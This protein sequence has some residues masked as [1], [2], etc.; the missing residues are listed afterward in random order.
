MKKYFFE[1]EMIVAVNAIYAI[2]LRSLKRIQ[3]FNRVWNR[4]LA[5]PVRCSTNWAMK[6]LTL[7][8]GQLWVHIW[9]LSFI[10]NTHFFHGNIWTHNWPAPNVSGFL[11][12]LVE[13]RTGIARTRVQTPLK[14]WFFCFFFRLLY[15]I[16]WIAFTATIISF[17]IHFRSSYII[18]FIH[19]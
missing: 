3:D 6:P 16:A 12:Q 1:K 10:I 17:S 2:A 8:V 14:S 7:G 9:F 15:G 18:Y 5:M 11:A 19:H 13:H 4:E